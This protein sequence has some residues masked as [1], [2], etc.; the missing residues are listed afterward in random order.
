MKRTFLSLVEKQID[1]TV[2]A[3]VVAAL[4]VIDKATNG[5]SRKSSGPL[6]DKLA[7]ELDK[8]IKRAMSEWIMEKGSEP[9]ALK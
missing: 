1:D 5:E 8:V 2:Y 3:A 7:A 9:A 4:N 6:G